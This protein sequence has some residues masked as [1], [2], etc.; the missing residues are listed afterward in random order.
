MKKKLSAWLISS[1]TL[2]VSTIVGTTI[3]NWVFP[4]LGN[5]YFNLNSLNFNNYYLGYLLHPFF[6]AFCLSWFW[7][8][9]KDSFD[10]WWLPRCVEFSIG[11]TLIAIL[12]IL[13]ILY[14]TTDLSFS[15]LAV[16]I[17]LGVCQGI[18]AGLIFERINP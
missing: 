15:Y 14:C 1:G 18:I 13:W 2:F 11:Y 5:L 9:C 4:R 10:G 3:I 12:P 16:F 7:N 17:L 8:H 6:L